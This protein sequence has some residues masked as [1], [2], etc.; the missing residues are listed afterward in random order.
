MLHARRLVVGAE[1]N[2]SLK[3]G[4]DHYL[5]TPAGTCKGWLT[6]DDLV[7]VDLEGRGLVAEG[8][9]PSSEWG[10]HR[11]IYRCC[12]EAGAVCHG[13]PGYATACASA[14]RALDPRLLTETAMLLGAVPLA[15][16]AVPGTAEVAASVRPFLPVARA[17]LL[18][19]HGVVAWGRDLHEAYFRLETVERLAEVTVLSS[20]LGGGRLLSAEFLA[21]A[22][23]QLDPD[24]AP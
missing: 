16:P 19:N 14:G 22:G 20:I 24:E 4:D 15:P 10:L 18:A 8:P 3:L 12:P 7:E 21:R 9:L 1:G 2:L 23:V 11:E 17:V 13:H 6:P 5:T